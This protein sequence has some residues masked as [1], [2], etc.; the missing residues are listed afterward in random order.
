M[1]WT[2]D[3]QQFVEKLRQQHDVAMHRELLIALYK[4]ANGSTRALVDATG[5]LA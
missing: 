1:E 5:G 2:W 3:G 4:K